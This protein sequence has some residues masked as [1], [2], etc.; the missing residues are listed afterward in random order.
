VTQKTWMY[1][2]AGAALLLILVAVGA[3]FFLSA[4]TG[5]VVAGGAGAAATV[6]AGEALRRRQETRKEVEEAKRSAEGV[7]N[8]VAAIHGEAKDAM[9]EEAA[10]VGKDS[11]A[12]KV[13]DGNNLF[14]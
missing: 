9:A 3:Y 4:G 11:D 1:V 2:A 10:K 12:D 13:V 8:Q 14:G 5:G 7:A 6:A